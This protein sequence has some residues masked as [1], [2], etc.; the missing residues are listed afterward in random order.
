MGVRCGDYGGECEYYT[1]EEEDET[2]GDSD[3][4]DWADEEE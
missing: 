2:A 4:P 1:L 3:I